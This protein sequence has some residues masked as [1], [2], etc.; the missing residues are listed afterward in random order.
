MTDDCTI[1]NN[2]RKNYL[3]SD[4][5]QMCAMD[6]LPKTFSFLCITVKFISHRGIPCESMISCG[7]KYVQQ[8]EHFWH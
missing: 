8:L 5:K 2:R 4:E 7:T 1:Y 3:I 6:L